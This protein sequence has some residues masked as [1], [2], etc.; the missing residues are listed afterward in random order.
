MVRFGEDGGGRLLYTSVDGS[1]F[2]RPIDHSFVD[3]DDELN[4]LKQRPTPEAAAAAAA[5]AALS[6]QQRSARGGR[7][8]F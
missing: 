8:H 7:R 3:E 1:H 4:T 2:M 6:T 5:A